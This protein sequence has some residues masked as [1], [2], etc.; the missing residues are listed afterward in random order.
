MK[1]CRRLRR[2]LCVVKRIA[3][4]WQPFREPSLQE[5][6][7]AFAVGHHVHLSLHLRLASDAPRHVAVE[8]NGT[9]GSKCL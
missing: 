9:E 7:P 2:T 8:G 4:P 3:L 6:F 1:P 5:F